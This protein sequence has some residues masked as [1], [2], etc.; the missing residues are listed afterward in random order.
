MLLLNTAAQSTAAGS[1]SATLSRLLGEFMCVSY[2]VFPNSDFFFFLL[3][4]K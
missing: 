4:S 2:S 1:N 3:S